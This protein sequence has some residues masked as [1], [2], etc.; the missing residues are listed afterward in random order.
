MS[1]RLVVIGL[2]GADWSL[3]KKFSEEGSLPNFTK[4][5][6]DGEY[7]DL[8]SVQPPITIPAWMCMFTGN[9]PVDFDAYRLGNLPVDSYDMGLALSDSFY[10]EVW[11]DVEDSFIIGV[12][13]T[14]PAK[15]SVAT[16]VSGIESPD[17]D[18]TGFCNDEGFLERYSD[19][20][21]D[22][23]IDAEKQHIPGKERRNYDELVGMMDSRHELFMNVLKNEDWNLLINVFMATDRAQHHMYS[24]DKE[25]L[26]KIYSRIDSK[27]G[28]VFEVI[29]DDDGILIVSDHG[30][31]KYT[32]RFSLNYWL[33]QNGYLKYKGDG[34][35]NWREYVKHVLSKTGLMKFL[36]FLPSKM[37]EKTS[38]NLGST[39]E[40]DW[41]NTKAFS[42]GTCGFIYINTEKRPEGIVSEEEAEE[43]K[44]EIIEKLSRFKEKG[45]SFEVFRFEDQY[46]ERTPRSPALMMK[47]EE[48][49]VVPVSKHMGRYLEEK[50]GFGW[51]RRKGVI[52]GKNIEGL[53]SNMAINEVKKIILN[54]LSD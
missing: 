12:P 10:G 2:D 25:W 51:H 17:T 42:R 15:D 14:F 23:K 46:K 16:I 24:D 49:D 33:E 3:I 34:G 45:A 21:K 20:L 41:K 1:N 32:H 28:E 5:M 29:D 43:I 27:L 47:F 52:M 54:N 4:L 7:G 19:I 31:K 30:F 13:G 50:P 6:E 26:R 36:K 48:G 18:S 8:I 37:V 53:R 39:K 11:E 35:K 38:R 40:I 22:Y 9:S 44:D